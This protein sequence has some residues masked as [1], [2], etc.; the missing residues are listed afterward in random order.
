M[1]PLAP[2][3]ALSM[4]RTSSIGLRDGLLDAD[5]ARRALRGGVVPGCRRGEV[6]RRGIDAVE[7]VDALD[8]EMPT[9]SRRA[10]T[11]GCRRDH[12]VEDHRPAACAAAR[13]PRP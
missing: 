5:E 8:R 10:W 13:R 7:V 12:L 3:A 4:S 6:R 11:R 1:K 9:P 2:N